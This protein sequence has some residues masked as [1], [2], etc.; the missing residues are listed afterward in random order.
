ME[1]EI[2]EFL[3]ESAPMPSDPVAFRLALYTRLA[4]VEQI[5]A[6][7]DQEYCNNRRTLRIVF[8]AGIFIGVA[9]AV[10]VLL[11]PFELP[12]FTDSAYF[13]MLGPGEGN[14]LT[15]A[16]MILGVLVAACA[17]ILPLSLSRRRSRFMNF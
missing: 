2:R 14:T 15:Y 3:H 11:H 9:L 10:L 8:V 16:W 7:R 6:Y 12:V 4:A 13:A 1:D 17:I 5:K